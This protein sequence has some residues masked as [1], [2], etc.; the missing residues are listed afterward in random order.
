MNGEN[1][2]LYSYTHAYFLRTLLSDGVNQSSRSCFLCKPQ[3][4]CFRLER[5][6]LI[7]TRANRVYF[8]NKIN[9]DKIKIIQKLYS[10]NCKCNHLRTQK[11]SCTVLLAG[12]RVK[13][14]THSKA[15]FS[16]Y[17]SYWT[18]YKRTSGLHRLDIF[19]RK[20]K[21]LFK[22]NFLQ[23]SFSV[24]IFLLYYSH[25]FMF[26]RLPS[27]HTRLCFLQGDVKLFLLNLYTL[28]TLEGNQKIKLKP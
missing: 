10:Q 9:L 14:K 21:T 23:I 5:K 3:W 25:A 19:K 1:N 12:P 13:T 4:I 8:Q 27:G 16:H 6:S 26:F 18:A 15:A 28:L 20:I 11:S 2:I 22:C 17:G 7:E 24:G